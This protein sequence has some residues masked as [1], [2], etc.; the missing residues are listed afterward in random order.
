MEYTANKNTALPTL[1]QIK[2]NKGKEKRK[3]EKSIKEII[4]ET[5]DL[6]NDIY[7]Y[8]VFGK[9]SQEATDEETDYFINAFD[10]LQRRMELL[11][12]KYGYEFENEYKKENLKKIDKN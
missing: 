5:Q 2:T 12:E 1:S 11:Y 6:L 9:G 10:D 3:M 8:Y 7:N 4:I